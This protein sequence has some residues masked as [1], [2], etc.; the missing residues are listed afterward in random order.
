MV[1]EIKEEMEEMDGITEQTIGLVVEEE[2][3]ETEEMETQVI[4]ETEEVEQQT[5]SRVLQ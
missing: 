5:Q 3:L 1:Q 4:Q 2:Q